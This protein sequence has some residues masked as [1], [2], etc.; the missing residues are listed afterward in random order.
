MVKHSQVDSHTRLHVSSE[1]MTSFK[2]YSSFFTWEAPVGGRR[3]WGLHGYV[4]NC[5]ALWIEAYRKCTTQICFL[6]RWRVVLFLVVHRYIGSDQ[7]GQFASWRKRVDVG[8]S[9]PPPGG[10]SRLHSSHW[11]FD[12]PQRLFS[13]YHGSSRMSSTST[14]AIYTHVPLY[15]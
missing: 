7:Q 4:T 9:Q 1:G 12:S 5:E 11:R 10:R 3:T 13:V 15:T 14:A 8:V 6:R 2:C